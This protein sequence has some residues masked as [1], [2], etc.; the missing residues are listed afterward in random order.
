MPFREKPFCFVE[1]NDIRVADIV[2]VFVILPILNPT[3][4]FAKAVA[5]R[6]DKD[7]FAAHLAGRL[8]FGIPVSHFFQRRGHSRLSMIVCGVLNLHINSLIYSGEKSNG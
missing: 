8:N 4:V 2:G 3:A 6:I 1:R 7:V 5:V